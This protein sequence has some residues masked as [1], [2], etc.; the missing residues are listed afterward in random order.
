MSFFWPRQWLSTPTSSSRVQPCDLDGRSD[1]EAW[2][3]Y[4]QVLADW[5]PGRHESAFPGGEDYFQMTAR[6]ASAMRGALRHPP[7]SWVLFVGHGAIIRAAIPALC[8]GSPVPGSDLPNCGIAELALYP[9]P[10]G[11]TGRLSHW[12]LTL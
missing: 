11:V 8:P 12:P 6:L 1:E 7:G 10:A 4:H 3:V 9:G 5:R 2:T